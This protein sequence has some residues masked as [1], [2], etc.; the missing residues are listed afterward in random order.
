MASGNF[1]R[2]LTAVLKH[3]GGYV[4]HPRDPGGATNMGI[5]IS[6]LRAWRGKAVG[7]DDVR[8]LRRDEATQIYR[9]QYWNA[10]RSDDLPAGLDYAMFDYA[11]NSGAG[12][13]IRDL[14]SVLGLQRDGQIGA[15]TLDAVNKTD[16]RE[17]VSALM[18]KRLAFLRGLRTWDA[19]GKG[20][21][22]R[23]NDVRALSL[24]MVSG[25]PMVAPD[26]PSP[27]PAQGKGRVSDSK[28]TATP[29]GKGAVATGIGA[30]GQAM[31]EAANKIAPLGEISTA[32]HVI[33]GVM[34]MAG[35]AF[36]IWSIW[37][38]Y[39]RGELA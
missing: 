25:R 4:D 35:A 9:K 14:Q 17:L 37:Q 27:T 26:V 10:V 24:A 29:E 7:K 2:A 33:F 39:K 5:T 11:V 8:F 31:T 16:T 34:T 3:E 15:M 22:R 1:E 30:A 32:F 21:T 38:R 12:K 6:T 19:F 28:T 20:W 23:V 36:L 18:A 13:A